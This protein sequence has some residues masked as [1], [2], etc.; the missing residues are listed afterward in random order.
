MATSVSV[1]NPSPAGDRG[2]S[3]AHGSP[4]ERVEA[5]TTEPKPDNVSYTAVIRSLASIASTASLKKAPVCGGVRSCGA[6]QVPPSGR[7]EYWRCPGWLASDR[8]QTAVAVPVL[9]TTTSGELLCAPAADTSSADD[10]VPL[11]D[12]VAARMSSPPEAV[13][14]DHVTV[15]RPAVLT[16]TWGRS[17]TWSPDERVFGSAKLPPAGRTA[18]WTIRSSTVRYSV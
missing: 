1:A 7:E 15:H 8:V 5:V 16:P 14:S 11:A 4:G 2:T 18:L 3:A 12:R 17:A 6:D 9:S 13:S 10:Q